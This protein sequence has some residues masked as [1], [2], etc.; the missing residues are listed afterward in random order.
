MTM[1]ALQASEE[2]FQLYSKSATGDVACDPSGNV[3]YATAGVGS[4]F[5]LPEDGSPPPLASLI[6]SAQDDQSESRQNDDGR[7]G[8]ASTSGLRCRDR[9][10]FHGH[11]RGAGISDV[12]QRLAAAALAAL[13]GRQGASCFT[14]STIA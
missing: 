5:R 10:F 11:R 13:A 14:R 7:V 8:I 4:L 3:A 2:R 9:L 6:G 12:T 1:S